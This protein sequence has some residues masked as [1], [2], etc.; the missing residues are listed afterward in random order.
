MEYSEIGTWSEAKLE[1]VRDY[2][3][4]YSKILSK[5]EWCKAHVYIDAFA[6][7]GVHWARLS[8]NPVAGS[9]LNALLVEP[10]FVE[11]HFI[12]LDGK[13]VRALEEIAGDRNDVRLYHGDCNEVL[14]RDIFPGL[15]FNSYR[16]ALCLLDPYGLHLKWEVIRRAGELGTVDIFLNFP[17]HDINRNVLVRNADK[18]DR[19][20]VAR[21]NDFWGDD[22][23]RR[24]AY[25]TTA[26]LFGFEEKVCTND[27]LAEAFR[28]R[29]VEVAGFKHVPEPVY[30]RNSTRAGLYY[31][32]FASQRPV[33]AHIVGHIF[34][35]YRAGTGGRLF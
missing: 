25:A 2:G 16:R 23:W 19:R 29:L 35:K 10:P 7:P 27:Q 20:Q 13:R 22:S 24:V 11:H 1:I 9:P 14:V 21:M 3:K 34:D 17:I 6:G 28:R 31:L 26:N 8:G 12:D 33:A 4:E 32:F 18:M 5:Q 15:A 30:M